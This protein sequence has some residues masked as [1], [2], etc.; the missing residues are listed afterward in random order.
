MCKNRLCN[1]KMYFYQHFSLYDQSLYKHCIR[2][3]ICTI[4]FGANHMPRFSLY[5]VSEN[6]RE[7]KNYK[8]HSKWLKM[9]WTRALLQVWKSFKRLLSPLVRTLVKTW[10]W[11]IFLVNIS[12]LFFLSCCISMAVGNFCWQKSINILSTFFFGEKKFTFQL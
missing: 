4:F 6:S 10:H 12:P 5:W 1:K 8:W 11:R 9:Q 7:R 2:L 3:S